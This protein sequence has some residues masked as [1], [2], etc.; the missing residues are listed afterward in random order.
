MLWNISV[1]QFLIYAA[2]IGFAAAIIYTNIQRTAYSKFFTFLLD[3]SCFSEND[4]KTLNDIGLG[5]IEKKIVKSAIKNQYGFKKY[6]KSVGDKNNTNEIE[7]FFDADDNTSFYLENADT[8]LLRKKYSFKT[9]PT[10][11]VVLFIA[12]L[13]LVV[14]IASSSVSWLID[15][16]TA[17]KLEETDETE[18]TQDKDSDSS[19]EKEQSPD[20]TVPDDTDSPST[21]TIPND[22]TGDDIPAGPRIP[23]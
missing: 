4:A 12:A 3:N 13:A 20:F 21:P 19:S 5:G 22:T 16:V 8:E 10:K 11:L 2:G 15:R 23:I 1:F 14:V 7:A 9:M 6:V 18:Q 17:P